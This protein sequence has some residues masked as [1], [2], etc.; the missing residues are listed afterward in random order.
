[1]IA[2]LLVEEVVQVRNP[3]ETLAVAFDE[4]NVTGNIH[5]APET[6]I[7]EEWHLFITLEGPL[8]P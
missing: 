7:Q 1:V 5:L 3:A 8:Q 4:T 2:H 6:R